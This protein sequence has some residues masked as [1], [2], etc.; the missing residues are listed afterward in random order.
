MAK[1]RKSSKPK[2]NLHAEIT[3]NIIKAIETGPGKLAMPWHNSTGLSAIPHNALS[4]KAY[5][6]INI[7]N[8]WAQRLI[9]EYKTDLWGTYRQ[10]NELGAQVRKGEKSSLIIFYK[11]FQVEPDTFTDLKTGQSLQSDDDGLRRMARASYVFNADQV[12]GYEL[13]AK[14]DPLGPIE[15]IRA[16]DKLYQRNFRRYQAWRRTRLFCR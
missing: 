4:K 3:Q 15:R 7:V 12:D 14:P 10:W 5:N 1:T 13:P 16:A 11:E 6:G 8:L 2:R 9:S